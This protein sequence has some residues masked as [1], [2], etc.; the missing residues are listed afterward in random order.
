[1]LFRSLAVVVPGH[2]KVG[3]ADAVRAVR[4]YL[5]ALDALAAQDPGPDG[6]AGD[7][8]PAEL[9]GWEWPE[10]LARNLEFLR[11]RSRPA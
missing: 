10:Q 1:M 2:G 8:L 3:G 6:A 7:G 9:A 5:D 4:R 11:A